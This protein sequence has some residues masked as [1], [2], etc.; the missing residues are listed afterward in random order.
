MTVKKGLYQNHTELEKSKKGLKF[1]FKVISRY[2]CSRDDFFDA[3]NRPLLSGF[4]ND[5]CTSLI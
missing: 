4:S 1:N 3:D 5:I 2:F